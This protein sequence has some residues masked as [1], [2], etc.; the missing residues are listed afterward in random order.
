MESFDL[1]ICCKEVVE[2]VFPDMQRLRERC[3]LAG[4]I[5][6]QLRGEVW[7]LLLSGYVASDDEL[8]KENGRIR[9]I[10]NL[11]PLSDLWGV[12][13]LENNIQYI[14]SLFCKRT[15]R[16]YGEYML[17]ILA[18]MFLCSSPMSQSTAFSCFYSLCTTYMPLQSYRL[19][20]SSSRNT[21]ELVLNAMV[22]EKQTAWLRLMVGYHF[23]RLQLHLDSVC[24]Q[25]ER[26]RDDPACYEV[27]GKQSVDTPG[28]LPKAWVS[29]LYAG[30]LL[31][32][33]RLLQLWDWCLLWDKQG[34][35]ATGVYLTV[36]LLGLCQDVLLRM[37][38]QEQ[39]VCMHGMT[40]FHCKQ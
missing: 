15:S 1:D 4:R 7:S 37:R 40:M 22:V 39:V 35:L 27:E 16:A 11:K 38:T 30:S 17:N 8:V 36:A 21:Q 5:P 19:D 32:P 6:V 9:E 26:L 28:L 18:P 14:L 24:P 12:N 34:A 13:D 2:S 25:W 3:I 29:A 10:V 20:T 31:R 23:P 33:D